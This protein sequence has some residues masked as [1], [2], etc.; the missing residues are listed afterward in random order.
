MTSTHDTVMMVPAATAEVSVGDVRI[1]TSLHQEARWG[2]SG[3]T[4]W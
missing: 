3:G 2:L 1:D 4:A